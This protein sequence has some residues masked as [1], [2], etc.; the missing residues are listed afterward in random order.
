MQDIGIVS[1][2]LMTAL[3]TRGFAQSQVCD[4]LKTF[5]AY[6]AVIAK[7]TDYAAFIETML[8]RSFST[9]QRS[10]RLIMISSPLC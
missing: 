1:L 4:V 6:T 10:G 3:G 7:S 8:M 2:L 5:Y 9:K